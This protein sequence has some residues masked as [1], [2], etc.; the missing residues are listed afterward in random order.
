MIAKTILKNKRISEGITTP[1]LKLS[2]KAIVINNNNNN[3]KTK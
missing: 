3:N 2:F 1:D